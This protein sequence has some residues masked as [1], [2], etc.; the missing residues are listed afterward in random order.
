MIQL[1]EEARTA[2]VQLGVVPLQFESI[3]QG[4]PIAF[5]LAS[6]AEGTTVILELSAEER[7]R[8]GIFTIK[9]ELDGLRDILLFDIRAQC[10]ARALGVKEI[11]IMGIEINNPQ[12]EA[13]LIHGGYTRTTGLVPEELGGGTFEA[14]S[15]VE[16]VQ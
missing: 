1:T 3:V 14:L 15:R 8:I 5:L 16:P 13:A 2:L 6:A 11:E 7:L 12:L 9:N 4:K 10:V